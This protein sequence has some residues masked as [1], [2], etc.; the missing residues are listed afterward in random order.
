M[1]QQTPAVS[2]SMLLMGGGVGLAAIGSSIAFMAQAL[3]KISLWNVVVVL[4][5]VIL[6]FGGPVV[7]ISLVKLYRR[8]VAGFLEAGG[9]ALNKRLRLS[10]KMGLIFTNRPRIPVSSFLNPVDVVGSFLKPATG[11]RT[12]VRMSAGKRFLLILL[13]LILGTA[14]GLLIWYCFLRILS[15]FQ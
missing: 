12:A 5:C 1:K 9:W 8:N 15:L 13:A 11:I 2:G 14:T 10:R 4:L 7:I 6:I 3:H